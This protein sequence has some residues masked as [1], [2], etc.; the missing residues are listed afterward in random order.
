MHCI[1]IDNLEKRLGSYRDYL[2]VNIV[3]TF[4]NFVFY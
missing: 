4:E 3:A 2:A 1:K